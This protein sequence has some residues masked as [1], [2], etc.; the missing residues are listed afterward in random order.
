MFFAISL[1]PRDRLKNGLTGSLSE[2]WPDPRW[3]QSDT[4]KQV[5]VRQEEKRGVLVRQWGGGP[6]EA[7]C[8]G[9]DGAWR[10]RGAI[11]RGAEAVKW[12]VLTADVSTHTH[13]HTHFF[14]LCSHTHT[15]TQTLW[16]HSADKLFL[17]TWSHSVFGGSNGNEEERLDVLLFLALSVVAVMIKHFPPF[18][19]APPPQPHF[20]NPTTTTSPSTFFSS[21][22]LHFGFHT[23]LFKY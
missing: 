4:S 6:M 1:F 7:K 15:H 12:G 5:A 2:L 13:T 8:R 17:P 3:N 11:L 14:C 22:L 23:A 21:A 19:L 18:A 16:P 10:V 20:L 9:R